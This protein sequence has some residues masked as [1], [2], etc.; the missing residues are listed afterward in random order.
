MY[1]TRS[2]CPGWK[3]SWRKISINTRQK[4][5]STAR[6]RLSWRVSA[7]LRSTFSVLGS[8][9]INLETINPILS[10]TKTGSITKLRSNLVFLNNLFKKHYQNIHQSQWIP[11]PQFFMN[12]LIYSSHVCEIPHL[13]QKY[14]NP[15]CTGNLRPSGSKYWSSSRIEEVA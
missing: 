8:Q 1:V 3:D 4:I 15:D 9:I 7:S 5:N 12:L 13:S 2:S 10:V 14:K 6:S 11:L